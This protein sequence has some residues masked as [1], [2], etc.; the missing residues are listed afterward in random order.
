MFI[1]N[2]YYL[3]QELPYCSK[4]SAL[5]IIQYPFTDWKAYNF[6]QRLSCMHAIRMRLRMECWIL[7]SNNLV[8]LKQYYFHAEFWETGAWWVSN[9]GLLI[10][11]PKGGT[12]HTLQTPCLMLS[13][14]SMRVSL[15]KKLPLND[16]SPQ[17]NSLLLLL[18]SYLEYLK[19]T[20]ACGY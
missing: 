15:I 2:V 11:L 5:L 3:K 10:S 12:A 17:Q 19:E 8:K 13:L 18:S 4:T 7:I 16:S 14:S 20:L 9:W 6:Q 1:S